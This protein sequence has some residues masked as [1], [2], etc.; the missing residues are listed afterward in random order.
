MV[1]MKRMQRTGKE[2]EQ[3]IPMETKIV[4][5]HLALAVL[6]TKEAN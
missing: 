4:C 3:R 2:T 1:K 6:S 5:M